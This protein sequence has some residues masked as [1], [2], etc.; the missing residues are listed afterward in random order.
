MRGNLHNKIKNCPHTDCDFSNPAV[1]DYHIKNSLYPQPKP[2]MK[3]KN[4]NQEGW[5]QFTMLCLGLLILPSLAF[6]VETNNHVVDKG[7]NH[8]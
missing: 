6:S 1:L 5:K 8:A 3:A 4:G 2:K 7:A